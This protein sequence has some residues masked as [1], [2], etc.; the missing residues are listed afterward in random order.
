VQTHLKG[1][2][3]FVIGRGGDHHA[4]LGLAHKVHGHLVPLLRRSVLL[5]TVLQPAQGAAGYPTARVNKHGTD[6][7][8]IGFEI[9]VVSQAGIRLSAP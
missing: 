7:D 1:E 6:A 5:L 9:P 3:L 4:V 2:L 8:A